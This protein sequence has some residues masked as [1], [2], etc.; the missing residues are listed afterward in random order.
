MIVFAGPPKTGKFVV[1]R[2]GGHRLDRGD[3][4]RYR[5]HTMRNVINVV[6]HRSS[7][8]DHWPF[9][10]DGIGAHGTVQP[11]FH[12]GSTR[13]P[14]NTLNAHH[15]HTTTT[16]LQQHQRR[17]RSHW[18]SARH[19]TASDGILQSRTLSTEPTTGTAMIGTWTA[20]IATFF[21][22]R[23]TIDYQHK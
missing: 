22:G 4:Q 16:T 13:K 8:Y 23:T 15:H 2:F 11:Q 1:K 5:R 12:D 19:N 7:A 3:M 10:D 18:T 17:T 20:A 9:V 6:T 14:E 21:G